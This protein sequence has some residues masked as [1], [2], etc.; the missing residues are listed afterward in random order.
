MYKVYVLYSPSFD[1]IYIGYT[2]NLEERLKS[3]NELGH[4]G[5]TKKYRPWILFRFEE[6]NCKEAAIKREKELKSG[7]G[8]EF[9][10]AAIRKQF[11]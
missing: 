7:Q 5:W 2:S 4:T 3:H 9:I 10:R 11:G 1:K 6:F 8:R